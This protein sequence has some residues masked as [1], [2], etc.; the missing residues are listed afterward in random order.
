MLALVLPLSNF[1]FSSLL[2]N[3]SEVGVKQPSF[4][5]EDK[6]LTLKIAERKG[7]KILGCRWSLPI[8]GLQAL[9]LG[10]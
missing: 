8:S 5:D 2:G 7:E 1:L 4:N 10:A 9:W 6:N 3:Q